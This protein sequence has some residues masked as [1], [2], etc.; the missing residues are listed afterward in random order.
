M[1]VLRQAVTADNILEIANSPEYA[2]CAV[3]LVEGEIVTMPLTSPQHGEILFALGGPL[4]SFVMAH[5][6]G[7][8]TGGDAGFI[9]ERNPY[10]R[11]SVR[12]IDIAFISSEKAQ[13]TL[14]TVFMEGAPDLAIEIMSPSNTMTDIR[15]KINQ[16]LQAGCR[17]VWIVH[18]DLRE[19]DAHTSE[20]AKIHREGD[21]L[22][23]AD[24][25]PGFEVEVADIFPK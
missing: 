12:G 24:I 11:D 25:P 3:E 16:L 23:A 7:R 17:Q 1:T 19:V 15:L 8:V 20:G 5:G 21:K 10:G 18:P 6:L 2:D 22:S 9:L 13:G 4:R 14:P